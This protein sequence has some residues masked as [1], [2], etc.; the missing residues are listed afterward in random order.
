MSKLL[1]CII[2]AVL[3]ANCLYSNAQQ[4]VFTL[5][6]DSIAYGFPGDEIP[7]FGTISN[8]DTIAIDVFVERMENNI[9]TGWQSYF[10]TDVCLMPNTSIN[11]VNVAGG[12]DQEFSLHFMTDSIPD[13]GNA[14]MSFT[15]LSNSNNFFIQ[16]MYGISDSAYTGA[17]PPPLPHVL[18][19]KLYPNPLYDNRWLAVKI[20]GNWMPTVRSFNFVLYDVHG[21][22]VVL[23][24]NLWHNTSVLDLSDL[25][26]GVYAYQ[27]LSTTGQQVL[28]KG[29]LIIR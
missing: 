19:A 24:H 5:D 3:L 28:Q 22:M 6:A 7:I 27:L 25:P 23:T 26:G 18:A 4:I 1:P 14:L 21:R 10:C 12:Y 16:R 29:K 8:T 20:P 15:N 11:T 9:P 13:S 17:D 2:S